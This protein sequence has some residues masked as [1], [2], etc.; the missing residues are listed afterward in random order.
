MPLLF[1]VLFL[2]VGISSDSSSNPSGS[3]GFAIFCIEPERPHGGRVH[4]SELVLKEPPY[5]TEDQVESYDWDSHTI[6]VAPEVLQDQPESQEFVVMAGG[7]R[8]YRGYFSHIHSSRGYFG[9]PVI[10]LPF[11]PA[12][13]GSVVTLPGTEQLLKIGLWANEDGDPRF[14]KRLYDYLASAGL[15][16]QGQ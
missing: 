14:D 7:L 1:V 11:I 12:A 8:I 4:L 3:S 6:R 13:D 2:M 9:S 15:L 16:A 5:L 10:F